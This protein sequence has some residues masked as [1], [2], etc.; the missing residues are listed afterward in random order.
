AGSVGLRD[1]GNSYKKAG[2]NDPT[3]DRMRAADL[4]ELASLKEV[5]LQDGFLEPAPKG[6]APE[7]AAAEPAPAR[8][9]GAGAGEKPF[10]EAKPR[11]AGPES[12]DLLARLGL[13]RGPPP[14]LPRFTLDAIPE[15]RRAE[16]LNIIEKI[17]AKHPDKSPDSIAK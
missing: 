3:F 4:S 11:E 5:L 6:E 7:V 1:F 12:A 14:E 9:G 15:A 13:R 17:A 16:G 2:R 8:P 10:T